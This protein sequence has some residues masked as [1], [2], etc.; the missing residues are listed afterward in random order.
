MHVHRP[1]AS[2]CLGLFLP[3]TPLRTN[4]SS[5]CASRSHIAQRPLTRSDDGQV[6]DE[7][8]KAV[9]LSIDLSLTIQPYVSVRQ[10]IDNDS[11]ELSVRRKFAY[12]S[13]AVCLS[14]KHSL[15]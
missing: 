7:L 11:F 10:R 4:G 3:A 2:V 8:L 14:V 13:A 9:C 15:W 1:S 12:D 5:V 6:E